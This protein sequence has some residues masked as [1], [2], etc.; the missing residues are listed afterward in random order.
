MPVFMKLGGKGIA[1]EEKKLQDAMLR[2]RYANVP[3]V[4][5]LRG[6]ALGGG[7]ELAV[8][9][10]APRRAHGE[11]RRPGRGRRR[12][13][14][15]R[16]RPGLHRAPR[17]PRA[18]PRHRAPTCSTFLKEGFTAAATAKV[19]TSA[20]ESRKLGY[21]L[22]AR[23][24][25]RAQGRAAA[26]RDRAGQGDVRS[27]LSPAA[28][29]RCSRSRAA[30]PSRPSRRSSSACATAAS[31]AEHDFHIG[32][33]IAD[34]VCGGDVDAGIAGDRGIPDG[35]RA[36]AVLRAA[37]RTRRRR[38]A[39]WECCRPASRSATEVLKIEHEQA[40]A[41]RLHRRRHPHADRQ[42]GRAA[43]SATRGPTICSSPR[44][45]ARWSRCR[46]STRRRSRTPSSAARCPRASRA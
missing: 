22:D 42:V 34:V 17:A 35:A 41:G 21:L 39:S 15:G 33:L 14:S 12:P 28:A 2:I 40:S 32:S 37:R 4:S 46:R 16:R 6:M 10:R 3:V 30:R 38:N 23:R 5:A 9:S 1:P 27:G 25:R 44:S 26:R 31:S 24:D 29:R 43:T 13:D 20:L 8:Y 45:T 36:Q 11:L 18:P 7:C 19:G